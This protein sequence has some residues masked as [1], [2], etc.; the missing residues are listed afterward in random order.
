MRRMKKLVSNLAITSGLF[1]LLWVGSAGAAVIVL[2]FEGLQNFE[3]VEEFYNGGFGGNGSGPGTNVGASFSPDALAIIDSDA[4]GGGNFGGEPSPSTILFFLSN[5]AVLNFAAGF[6]TGFSFFYS[7]INNPGSIDV[8]DGLN[9]TGSLLASLSLPT[10]LSDGGDPN[11]DF[12]PF[13][14]VGV[15][16][17]GTAKSIDFGGTAVQIGFDNI[18][19]GSATPGGQ[20]TE[21]ATLF[22]LGIGLAGMVWI[23][24]K[25]AVLA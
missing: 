1:S 5:T 25:R 24:R 18:T 4:G 15:A 3:T 9:K 19:F 17:S 8:Y 13:F 14:P 21:P 20:V 7:A 23:A 22:L 2:D 6:D 12:S 10:T 16:F 11:G